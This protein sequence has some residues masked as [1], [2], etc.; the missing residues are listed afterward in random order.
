MSQSARL[1]TTG[2]GDKKERGG[3]GNQ[4]NT[5]RS[6]RRQNGHRP[7]LAV[8]LVGVTYRD[9]HGRHGSPPTATTTFTADTPAPNR[10]TASMQGTLFMPLAGCHRSH[11]QLPPPPSTQPLLPQRRQ[12]HGQWCISRPL[13][14]PLPP[15]P[16]PRATATMTNAAATAATLIA[17]DVVAADA[18]GRTAAAVGPPPS[19]T[20]ATHEENAG[21]GRHSPPPAWREEGSHSVQA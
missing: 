8:Q 18:S 20:A 12:A 3:E 4:T 17:T 2:K 6:W 1:C 9:G 7:W 13:A 11:R 10:K 5:C 16:P 19:A 14:T 21:G 15:P